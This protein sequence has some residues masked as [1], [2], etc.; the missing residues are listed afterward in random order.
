MAIIIVSTAL[1]LCWIWIEI[2]LIVANKL[3][4]HSF[5]F[6]KNL[7][8]NF[9]WILRFIVILMFL[10]VIIYMYFFDYGKFSDAIQFCLG[11]IR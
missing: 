1:F 9:S 4:S 5:N 2:T 10:M 7:H 6:N 11:A 8:K 3:S